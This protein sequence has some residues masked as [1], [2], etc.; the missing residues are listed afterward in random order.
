MRKLILAAAAIAAVLLMGAP[1]DR[2]SAMTVASPAALGL[3]NPEASLVQKVYWHRAWRPYWGWRHRS[4]AWHRPYW[5]W[6]R[7]YWAGWRPAYY[8]PRP[9]LGVYWG[10]PC[11]W[12]GWGGWGGWGWHRRWW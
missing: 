5:G 9:W 4:W 10:R 6:R 8:Y 3:A 12:G 7:Y 11:C 2:A 1:A